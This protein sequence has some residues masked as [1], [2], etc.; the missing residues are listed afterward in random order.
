VT[1]PGGRYLSLADA[2]PLAELLQ[3]LPFDL[4]THFTGISPRAAEGLLM[5]VVRERFLYGIIPCRVSLADARALL[6]G[7]NPPDHWVHVSKPLDHRLCPSCDQSY[8]DLE[9]NGIVIR[10]RGAC[11]RPE[12]RLPIKWTLDVPSGKMVV[13]NDLRGLFPLPREESISDTLRDFEADTLL[14]A[15]VGMSHALVGNSDPKV[16]R[17]DQ[18]RYE[19]ARYGSDEHLVPPGAIEVAR[20]LTDLRWYSICDHDEYQRRKAQQLGGWKG[21]DITVVDVMPGV[22]EFTHWSQRPIRAW[23]FTSIVWLRPSDGGSSTSSHRA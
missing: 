2:A 20:I 22:Y 21:P 17:L 4:N 18:G 13:A 16:Y 9:T 8:L 23:V 19:V 7:T 11:P 15:Q 10:V 6:E 14:Y 12:G 1:T 3:S 5:H